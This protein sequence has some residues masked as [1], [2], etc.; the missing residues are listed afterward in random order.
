MV[1]GS[2]PKVGTTCCRRSGQAQSGALLIVKLPLLVR[3][4]LV[5]GRAD[6][7]EWSGG[8]KGPSV[9]QGALPAGAADW[10]PARPRCARQNVTGLRENSLAGVIVILLADRRRNTACRAFQVIS[11]PVREDESLVPAGS[12]PTG[13]RHGSLERR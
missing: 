12:P 5:A 4:P 7:R 11:R 13:G 1:T 10:C 9:S 8:G 2:V 3:L 6:N